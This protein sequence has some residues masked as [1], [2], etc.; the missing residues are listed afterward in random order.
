M[1]IIILNLQI[2]LDVLIPIIITNDLEYIYSNSN[3]LLTIITIKYSHK[4]RSSG[5]STVNKQEYCPQWVIF[6]T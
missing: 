2:I 5:P 1:T 3:V 6:M 4:Q